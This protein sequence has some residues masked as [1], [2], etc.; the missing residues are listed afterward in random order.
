MSQ[1]L[2]EP[3]LVLLK[4]ILIAVPVCYS[5]CLQPKTEDNMH[6]HDNFFYLDGLARP[7]RTILAGQFFQSVK[8]IFPADELAEHRMLAV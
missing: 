4:R 2:R 6:A 5:V 8:N 7:F 1:F 3:R